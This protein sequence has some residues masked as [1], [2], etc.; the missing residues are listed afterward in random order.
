MISNPR[1]PILLS[2]FSGLLATASFPPGEFYW[3]AWIALVPFLAA[4]KGASPGRGFILGF[5][6]GLAHFLSMLYWVVWVLGYYGGIGPILS[7]VP[8]LL[9]CL[10][11][12]LFPGFFG[13]VAAK[14]NGT[15]FSALTISALWVSLEYARATLLT[16]FPWCLLGYSQATWLSIIQVA[17]LTGVYGISFLIVL[18]NAALAGLM[19]G[20][21]TK[22]TFS[23]V[24]EPALSAL[25][26]AGA[27]FYGNMRLSQ[28]DASVDDNTWISVALI[29]GNID[30]SVKWEKSYQVITLDKYIRLTHSA[31]KSG[32]DLVV[33]PETSVPFFLQEDTELAKKVLSL[34]KEA[35]VAIVAGSP[36]YKKVD[37]KLAY[38]NRAYIIGPEEGLAAYYDK[39][40][41]V[42]FGEY[43][44]LKKILSFVNRLVPAAGDFE[45]GSS[46]SPVSFGSMSAGI[47]I[48]FEA[49][50]PEISR[51]HAEKGADM[52]INIT[53]DAWFGKTSAP[54]Q[55][56]IMARFRA[57]ENKLPL[58]RAANT[59]ISTI[60]ADTGEII[61]SGGLFTE[62]VLTG[63]VHY[64]KYPK[65]FYTRFGDI[66]TWVLVCFSIIRV[67]ISLCVGPQKLDNVVSSES[68]SERSF[69]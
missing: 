38:L 42:P 1:L 35:K 16:G 9:L 19:T 44:P 34:A 47:I 58:L 60:I 27:L 61:A 14:I 2:L 63:R 46:I 13:A 48:C 51:K 53:N 21:K 4:L 68:Q 28:T 3:A 25:F 32:A 45:S 40:H 26:V 29:Q 18:V 33:W 65:T 10:Y 36:A 67:A 8:M 20:G 52:L 57:V 41:L 15:P 55:H 23:V 31:L 7:L 54:F 30:Q 49:I 12:S 59:G 5:V 56:M 37:N 11:L 69:A 6:W 66:F 39:V 22:K 24:W 43:V 50:F 64:S 62:D 17:D